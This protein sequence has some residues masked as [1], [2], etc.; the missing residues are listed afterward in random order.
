[1]KLTVVIPVYN[2]AA[3]IKA[4]L[5]AIRSVPLEKEILVVDDGSTDG[6]REALERL[7]SAADVRILRHE[8]NRGKGAALRTGFQAARGEVVVIQDA[9]LEY[10]PAEYPR[11]IEPILTGRAEAVY[12]SRFAAAPGGRWWH[13]AGNRLLTCLSNLLTG[14]DLTD[15]ETGH[16]AF[17]RDVLRTIEIQENRFGVE[18]EITA[19]LA[20]RGCRILEI[21]IAYRPRS[22]AEGKK[23]GF[24]DALRTLWCIVKYSRGRIRRRDL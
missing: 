16:K 7:D 11:L 1:M 8:R 5:Q 13:V 22:R 18:P 19:R 24:K 3:T 9:D 23:I 4:I 17:R 2:E 10:D 12:G 20:A 14:L 6:T 21:P 15:M